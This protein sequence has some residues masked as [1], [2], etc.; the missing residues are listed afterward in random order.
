MANKRQS[1]TIKMMTMMMMTKAVNCYQNSD[2]LWAADGQIRWASVGQHH[3][4]VLL[5]KEKKTT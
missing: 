5:L 2:H 1:M 4:P 3:R